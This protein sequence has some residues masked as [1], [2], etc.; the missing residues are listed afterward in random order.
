MAYWA[1]CAGTINSSS[2]IN[3]NQKIQKSNFQIDYRDSMDNSGVGET[4]L[5]AIN[6][7]S[8]KKKKDILDYTQT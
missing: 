5:K 8:G 2:V 3:Q 7:Q 4:L 1:D 6:S